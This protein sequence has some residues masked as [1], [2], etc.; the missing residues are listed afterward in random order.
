MVCERVPKQQDLAKMVAP[1][2]GS[3]PSQPT[4]SRC[5]SG[6]IATIELVNA[7]SKVLEIPRP[8]FFADSAT[9]SMSFETR[10]VFLSPILKFQRNNLK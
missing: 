1:V 5:V 3:E 10:A 7:I 2:L 4:I 6:K 8:F 9:E